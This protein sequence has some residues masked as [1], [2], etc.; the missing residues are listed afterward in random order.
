MMLTLKHGSIDIAPHPAFSW[1]AWGFSVAPGGDMFGYHGYRKFY[2]TLEGFRY[3]VL[4]GLG[5]GG[6]YDAMTK[7]NGW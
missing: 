7:E 1:R 2:I 4:I 5:R 3:Y 6:D